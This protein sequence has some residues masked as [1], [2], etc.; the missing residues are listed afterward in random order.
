[1]RVF[2]RIPLSGAALP[3]FA[4]TGQAVAAS[5]AALVLCTRSLLSAFT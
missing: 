2:S 5:G 3:D 4:V 1:M